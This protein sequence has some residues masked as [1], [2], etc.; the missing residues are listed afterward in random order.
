MMEI[1]STFK[2]KKTVLYKIV[3]RPFLMVL[4]HSVDFPYDVRRNSGF[5]SSFASLAIKTNTKY[6]KLNML[7]Y[8]FFRFNC[9][10]SSNH[11]I[12]IND[13]KPRIIK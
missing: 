13:K 3:L 11:I 7:I 8:Q 4:E 12:F 10:S 1:D 6:E 2:K 9:V 5:A